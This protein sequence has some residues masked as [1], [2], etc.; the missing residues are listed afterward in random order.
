MVAAEAATALPLVDADVVHEQRRSADRVSPL[1][2]QKGVDSLAAGFDDENGVAKRDCSF[3]GQRVEIAVHVDA[4][5]VRI[6]TGV[7][8]QLAPLVPPARLGAFQ[9]G[10]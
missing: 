4:R 3:P 1:A 6:D 5:T 9:R 8:D 10:T 2:S 7:G